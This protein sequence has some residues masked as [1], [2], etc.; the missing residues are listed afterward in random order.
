MLRIGTP[1]WERNPDWYEEIDEGGL[2]FTYRIKDNAP[3]K[4]KRSFEEWTKYNE[5]AE[6]FEEYQVK[7]D[8]DIIMGRDKL[9]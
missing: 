2:I 9:R 6:R 5:A 1:Y 7:V 3:E 4:A 8:W